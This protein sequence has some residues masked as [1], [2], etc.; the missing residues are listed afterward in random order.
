MAIKKSYIARSNNESYS[1]GILSDASYE[2]RKKESIISLKMCII[3]CSLESL[4]LPF[5]VL[6]NTFHNV[7]FLQ[8]GPCIIM[9]VVEPI[10]Y[11]MNDEDTKAII[12]EE[13]WYQGLKHM[14]GLH[15]ESEE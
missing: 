7:H 10:V 4:A 15:R 1:R 5:Y 6:F 9:F 13:N 12:V 11:L 3:G 14:L 2:R 8:Y